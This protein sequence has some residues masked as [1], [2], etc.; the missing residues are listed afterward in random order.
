MKK[1]GVR[2]SGEKK[3]EKGGARSET[4]SQENGNDPLLG[5]LVY[6]VAHY[7]RA[8]SEEA[9]T[10]GL[11]YDENGMGPALFCEAAERQGLSAS[12]VKRPNLK[13]IPAAVL[14]CVLILHEAQ[15]CVF[16]K[17]SKS[18]KAA[19]IFL[20]D[21]R[22]VRDVSLEKLQSDYAGYAVFTHPEAAFVHPET[23]QP[24]EPESHWF[25]GTVRRS[26]P[27]YGLVILASLFINLFVLVSPL[28]VMNVYDRVI[29]NNAIETG[30]ALGIGALAAFVFDFTFRTLR[31]Y[32]IDFAGRRTDIIAARRIY[33]QVLNM[34]LAERPE[35]S[36]AFANMLRDFDSV[37]EFFTSATMTV[38][39]D[40]PFSIVFLY[41]IFRLAGPVALIPVG[42]IAVV[43]LAG[44]L[45][46]F[47]LKGLVRKSV[48]SSETKHALLVETIHGLEAIKALGA[49]GKFRVRYGHSVA[50]NAASAQKSRFWSALS[51]NIATFFQQ[52]AS[53]III[54]CGMYL[55]QEGDLSMGGLIASVILGGRALA[56]IGQIANLMTRYHQAGNAL[57][58]LNGIMA[59]EVERPPGQ[60]FLHRPDLS[61][62]ISFD[63]VSF[64]Y[65]GGGAV[66]DEVSF[67]INPGEK[68][69]I[70]G[71]IGSGK[72]TALRL[73]MKLYEPQGGTIRMDDTDIRQ[74]DT[75]DLRRHMAYIAQD[76]VLFQGSVRDNIS[77]G[78]VHA[79]ESDILAA[80][81]AAGVHD[82]VS[83]HPMGYDAPVGEH[84]S[85]LSGGQRQAVALARAILGRPAVLLCDEP[86]NAMDMQAERVFCDY[87]KSSIADK[88][89][90]LVTHKHAM[91]E[92]VDR[93]ILM[94]EG[95]V[96]MD[97][98]RDEVVAALQSGAVQVKG[99][100]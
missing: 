3:K 56:P 66:L 4:A 50:D 80:A 25:W 34:K 89:L 81:K 63:K 1:A 11:A 12:V 29:P 31:G 42:L 26:M 19:Q 69:G 55:V 37:R 43:C 46:Q 48:K 77:A 65:R 33:D 76:V 68:V 24:D 51:V 14:P 8:Q 86:T 9:L 99:V 88:T 27:V 82:F 57:K 64:A 61:G 53:V 72:S 74:I 38:L 16:L 97:A 2:D 84:G 73:M 18:G 45:I 39:V 70:I 7:G 32:L 15:A 36:G 100:A 13:A 40:L 30:W 90:V 58:T 94:H 75:A 52:S 93:V 47:R 96:V 5:C 6:L 49:D 78:Y 59:R 62:K 60:K 91:L 87:V 22:S 10:A 44:L 92:L 98:P 21:T 35:S 20:P 71:R 23:V 83:R 67:T 17:K 28:F 41:F 95:K 54:L 79:G 85:G